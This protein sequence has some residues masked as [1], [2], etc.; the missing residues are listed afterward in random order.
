M[1]SRTVVLHPAPI[2]RQIAKPVLTFDAG[3]RTL[4]ADM[5]ETMDAYRGVGLAA[6]QIGVG[7]RVL[8]VG[9]KKHRFEIINPE[10]V[11]ATGEA[12]D[13]EGCL[14]LPGINVDVLRQVRVHVK[15]FSAVGRPVVIREQGFLARII[16]HE[17]DHL[18]GVLIIDKGPVKADHTPVDTA[19]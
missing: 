7:L 17:L 10:L 5:F 1:A 19:Q 13:E 15:G 14:S 2:L 9:Y 8:V 3:L 11:S 16:Q 18:N 4:V 12:L 6:P